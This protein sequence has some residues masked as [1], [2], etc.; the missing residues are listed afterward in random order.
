MQLARAVVVTQRPDVLCYE[1][2]WRCVLNVPRDV[3]QFVQ[4]RAQR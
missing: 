1:C 3:H 4:E 2:L